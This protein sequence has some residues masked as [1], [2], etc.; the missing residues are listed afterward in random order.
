MP[1]S[2]PPIDQTRIRIG[3]A[4]I[5]VVMVAA[6]VLAILIQNTSGRL[7]FGLVALFGAYRLFKLWRLMKQP[8]P[9]APVP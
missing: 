1:Q 5:A 7:V 6:I 2:P 4:L 9:P 3:F 8:P